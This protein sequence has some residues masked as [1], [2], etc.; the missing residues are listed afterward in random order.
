MDVLDVGRMAIFQDPLGAVFSVWQAGT[1][2]GFP[3]VG[4]YSLWNEPNLSE[5]LA[6][7]YTGGK[8]SSPRV[9]ASMAKAFIAGV[10]AGN[11]KA[12]VG[13]GETSPRGRQKALGSSSTQDTIAPGVFMQLVA[14]AQPK[15][16]FD[17]T[18]FVKVDADL[19]ITTISLYE[20]RWELAALEVG[21]GLRFGIRFPVHYEE[22]KPFNVSLTDV[23]FEV[24]PIEP[25]AVLEN[26]FKA[27]T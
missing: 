15:L 9:Y 22:G 26:L 1:H 17:V 4:Y 3:F 19:F 2:P 10:R 7:A 21:S 25:R 20:R 11:P 8:P 14:Q 12:Q 5:F 6:P 18:G 13:L 24:P 27:I 23:Q 16:K